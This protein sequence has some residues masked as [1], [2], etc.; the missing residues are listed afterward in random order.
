MVE[1][2][3]SALKFA[4]GVAPMVVGAS[5]F[6]PFF[7]D[8]ERL[9]RKVKGYNRLVGLLREAMA[10]CEDVGATDIRAILLEAWNIATQR[11]R[12]YEYEYYAHRFH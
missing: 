9:E 10:V 5:I 2:K 6:F 8:K 1:G 3:A 7:P 4:L 12:N 11:L